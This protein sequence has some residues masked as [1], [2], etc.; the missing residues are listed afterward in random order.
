MI[1]MNN[2]VKFVQL[3]PSKHCNSFFSFV[4]LSAVRVFKYIPHSPAPLPPHPSCFLSSVVASEYMTSPHI[5]HVMEQIKARIKTS[6][7]SKNTQKL[8]SYPF[9]SFKS[10]W[11]YHIVHTWII[12]SHWKLSHIHNGC[13]SKAW[14]RLYSSSFVLYSVAMAQPYIGNKFSVGAIFGCQWI[15]QKWIKLIYSC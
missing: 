4:I 3:N 10:I 2:R 7:T 1:H 15:E 14:F 5:L 12:Y 13:I 6:T 9:P 11:N 8:T